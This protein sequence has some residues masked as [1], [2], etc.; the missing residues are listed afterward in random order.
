L[1][2]LGQLQGQS[3]VVSRQQAVDAG[4]T[5]KAI[6]WRLRSGA[7]RRVYAGAYATFTGDPS[8]EARLWAAVMRVGP[9][10]ALSHETAAEIH[11]LTDKPSARI[12]ISVPAERRPGQ[13]R[14]IPG[15]IVHRS[16]CLVPEWQP[17]WHLPRTTVEDTVLDLVAAARTFDDAYGWISC[18]VGRRRTTP[19]LLS[20]ALAGRSRM[21]WRVWV[22]AALQDAADGVHSPLERNY[23]YGVERAHGLP[24]AQR[25]AKRRHGSGNRYLDNLYEEYGVCVELDGAAAHPAEGRWRDTHRDNANYVQG[26]GTLRYGWTDV[27][28]NRCQTAADVA[29]VLRRHGWKGTIR[30]CRPTCK[31]TQPS[32]D[33]R[34]SP[35]PPG[36]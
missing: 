28:E 17:P 10:A 30:P 2:W 29:I 11:G 25:Q 5:A 13:H 9:G 34:G 27:T 19:Q 24:K 7:W 14:E 4:F 12:H 16:R 23:V 18:A 20:K 6:D 32:V 35:L 21:R 1:T 33:D 31:A 22:T 15:V 26:T 36:G 3:G 8:R